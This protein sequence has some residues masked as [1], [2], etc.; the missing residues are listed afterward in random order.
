MVKK[1][2]V[3]PNG[4]TRLRPVSVI[5]MKSSLGPIYAL[6]CSGVAM[7]SAT[8]FSTIGSALA[9][10]APELAALG[11]ELDDVG[12]GFCVFVSCAWNERKQ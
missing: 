8:R 12:F 6:T 5:E 11:A 9:C 4:K 10:C 7:D 3:R 1:V 2:V